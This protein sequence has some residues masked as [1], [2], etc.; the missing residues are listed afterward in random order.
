MRFEAH[1]VRRVVVAASSLLLLPMA[2]FAA[3]DE[4]EEKGT[5][6]KTPQFAVAWES[7]DLLKVTAESNADKSEDF[8]L[9]FWYL[10]DK[11]RIGSAPKDEKSTVEIVAPLP[12]DLV[13]CTEGPAVPRAEGILNAVRANLNVTPAGRA[14]KLRVDRPTL[15]ASG[16]FVGFR[17]VSQTE[18]ENVC[19]DD[20]REGPADS[21]LK[22]L[23][24]HR[25]AFDLGS[26]LNL[27]GDGSW[28]ASPEVAAKFD[29]RWYEHV[30]VGSVFRYSAVGEIAEKPADDEES[31]GEDGE[32]DSDDEFDPF[33]SGGGSLQA[34]VFAFFPISSRFGPAVGFGISTLEGDDGSEVDAEAHYFVALRGEVEAYNSGRP[35]ES[36]AG[37]SAWLQAG[38]MKDD[39]YKDVVIEAA[40]ENSEEVRSDESDRAFLEAELEL[41][42]VGTNWFRMLVRAFAT[43]PTSGDGPSDIRVSVLGSVD[44]SKWFEGAR[45]RKK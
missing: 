45:G 38:W 20:R 11:K 13:A 1:R 41:P 44:P 43:V 19:S 8:C 10:K 30:L 40:T 28:N 35:A 16:G 42:R 36:L 24:K 25:L 22:V 14:L 34:Q 39:L 12:G 5:T 26:V 15:L 21:Q 31:D 32:G 33:Q 29:S 3:D 23:D 37:S 17:Y 2:A 9:S 27:D 18:A 4:S 7:Y 6:C